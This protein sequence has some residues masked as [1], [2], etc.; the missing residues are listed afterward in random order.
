MWVPEQN[1]FWQELQVTWT[2]QTW[3][4][5]DDPD[6]DRRD[7]L[8]LLEASRAAGL[9]VILDVRP[10]P[11]LVAALL[12]LQTMVPKDEAGE[13]ALAE[14]TDALLAR[15]IAGG[16]RCAA[17]CKDLVADFEW[18]GEFDCPCTG[19]GA[20]WPNKEVHYARYLGAVREGL[21]AVLPEARLWNGGYGVCFEDKFMGELAEHAG[22]LF[23]VANWH[24]YNVTEYWPRT[25][26]DPKGTPLYATPISE[27]VAH[28]A[29]LHEEMYARNRA[30]L[31]TLGAGQPYAS[32]E[33]G[34]VSVRQEWVDMYRKAF[35]EHEMRTLPMWDPAESLAPGYQLEGQQDVSALGDEE[36]ALFL[37]AWLAA[38]EQAGFEV[39]NYH[40]LRD[41]DR[42][43][44]QG[45]VNGG[46]DLKFWGYFCGLQFSDGT[47]K[48]TWDVLKR[49]AMK[50]KEA[51][52]DAEVQ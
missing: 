33:W 8:D 42:S 12:P 40:Y 5:F 17:L 9:R 52:T 32:S 38:R 49:W 47:P 46:C 29:R 41:P 13:R 37:D 18:W 27:C 44:L 48:A 22:Q 21:K 43:G 28:S 6:Q 50:A 16:A 26:N 23:D 4:D 36:A 39:V 2:K 1:E 30:L 51:H 19:V 7:I 45:A 24:D 10:S 3:A 25:D 14:K 34:I 20:I 35:H 31:D 15:M 11:G